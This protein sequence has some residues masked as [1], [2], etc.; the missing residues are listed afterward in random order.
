MGARLHRLS[1]SPATRMSRFLDS[2]TLRYSGRPAHQSR[3]WATQTRGNTWNRIPPSKTVDISR[4]HHALTRSFSPREKS[5]LSKSPR[6]GGD[7]LRPGSDFELRAP[8][9]REQFSPAPYNGQRKRSSVWV[10]RGGDS[11]LASGLLSGL[12]G[13]PPVLILLGFD[14]LL[15]TRPIRASLGSDTPGNDSSK[16]HL[17]GYPSPGVTRLFWGY[18]GDV[19]EFPG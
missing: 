16:L 18:Q 9:A 11:G 4:D 12:T 15:S 5:I 3:I 14:T 2:R 1:T 8:D 19:T 6:G 10:T 17:S 13:L 7:R